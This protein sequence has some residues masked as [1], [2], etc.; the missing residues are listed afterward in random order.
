MMLPL[1]LDCDITACS[2]VSMLVSKQSFATTSTILAPGA[3]P[4]TCVTSRVVS[5]AQPTAPHS[6]AFGAVERSEIVFTGQLSE[7][8]PVHDGPQSTVTVAVGRPK[9]VSKV[10]RS[11]CMVGLP[12]ASTITIVEPVP[13]SPLGKSY[14]FWRKLGG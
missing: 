8:A 4:C 6:A 13:S 7:A 2:A 11:D 1:R 10:F 3:S 14:A 12:K 5:S 9:V